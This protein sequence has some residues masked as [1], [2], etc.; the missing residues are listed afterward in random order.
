MLEN[1]GHDPIEEPGVGPIEEPGVGQLRE[2]M[3]E[4]VTAVAPAG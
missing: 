4:I 1:C 3:S 2:T